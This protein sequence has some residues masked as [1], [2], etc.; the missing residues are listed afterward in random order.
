MTHLDQRTLEASNAYIMEHPHESARLEGKTDPLRDRAQFE[1]I[2]LRPGMTVLDVGGGTGAVARTMAEVVGPRGQVTVMDRSVERLRF[3]QAAA[4]RA[5]LS[6][7][8]FT[9]HDIMSAPFV[10]D[11]FDLVWSRFTFEYLSDPVAALTN[12]IQYVRIGGKV[13][14]ADLDG[15][16]VVQYPTN[17]I[18]QHGT[19]LV[20]KCVD[21]LFDPYV[22][23]KLV[24]YF[25]TAQLLVGA[26]HVLP[27]HVYTGRAGAADLENWTLKLQ[28]LRARCI[29]AFGSEQAYDHYASEYLR[30]LTT[31]GV[32]MYST[33]IMVEGT[34]VV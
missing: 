18:V 25:H 30:Q 12:L 17:P 28:S 19:E 15:N 1:L 13:V 34:R 4:K 26:V 22:G 33:L 16:G 9:C 7:I 11:H 20:L 21:G 8:S 29:A 31:P 6:N 23:R 14:V 32:F 10:R 3:G 27:Y 5:S 2:G 24:H